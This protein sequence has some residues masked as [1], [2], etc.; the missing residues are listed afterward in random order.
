MDMQFVQSSNIY[1][2]GYDSEN[3][4]LTIEFKDSS[5]YEYYEVP[6][7]VYNELMSA[8]SHGKYA[9][10]NIYSIYRQNRVR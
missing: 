1:A 7:Y 4:T 6:E 2:I 10:Q 9:H 5:I 8:S 3:G